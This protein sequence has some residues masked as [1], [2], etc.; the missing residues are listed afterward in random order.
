[1]K[2]SSVI[3]IGIVLL[4][5]AGFVLFG[6]K[7]PQQAGCTMEA[8]ICPDGSAVGRGGPLCEFAPCPDVFQDAPENAPPII[9]A[10]EFAPPLIRANMRITKKPFGI[11]IDP[12]TSPVQPERF[13][14]YHTG[15]DF[16]TFSEETT[17]DV[18]V[19]AICNGQLLA[20]RSATGYGG[21]VVEKCVSGDKPIT[22]IY[23]HL[24]LTSVQATIGE[25]IAVGDIIG[26]LGTGQS[27]ETH[28]ERK[29]LHLGIHKGSTVDIRGYT[30]SQSELVD[31]FGPCQLFSCSL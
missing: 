28:G 25:D 9:N 16:E 23:G 11:F 2:K 8:Q 7:Q 26:V 4:G 17:S 14:G 19:R 3:I 15:T 13:R 22:V 10:S 12:K 6:K 5:A 29:H 20:K 27:R 18:S 30:A 31:W 21:V 1:M 24:R